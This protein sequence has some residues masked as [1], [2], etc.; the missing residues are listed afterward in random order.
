MFRMICARSVL[1]CRLLSQGLACQ[2]FRRTI[3]VFRKNDQ[4][5]YDLLV[6]DG[7]HKFLP[8]DKV[9]PS[10][11]T[12]AVPQQ[13]PKSA[14]RPYEAET[15]STAILYIT[16][17]VDRNEAC[18][19][20]KYKFSTLPREWN[21]GYTRFEITYPTYTSSAVAPLPPD[22]PGAEYP[23]RLHELL[24]TTWRIFCQ[25]DFLGLHLAVW[26]HSDGS[27]S[28]GHCAATLDE[29]ARHRQQEMFARATRTDSPDEIEAET[30]SL[31]LRRYVLS[32]V[33]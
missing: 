16:L 1:C 31:V 8:Q 28:F 11:E 17:S 3:T 19:K 25:K 18:V 20:G 14:P 2:N 15:A 13:E 21:A 26:C 29:N 23:E 22:L 7:F 4:F 10:S 5:L 32:D 24:E 9:I 12:E 6:R 27:M 30:S 33:Y